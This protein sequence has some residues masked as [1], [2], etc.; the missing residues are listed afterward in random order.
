MI[1]CADCEFYACQ[2]DGR[3]V[4]TCDPFVN[5]KEP[6]CLQKWQLMRL[7]MLVSNFH[8]M[9]LWQHKMAP[10]QEKLFKYVKRELDDIDEADSWKLGDDSDTQDPP[11][12][13]DPNGLYP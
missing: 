12:G 6:E 9:N 7:D 8:A 11:H 3:R 4:F 13:P 10:I 5:I 1:Q 2:P